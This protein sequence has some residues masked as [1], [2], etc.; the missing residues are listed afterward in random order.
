[1]AARAHRACPACGV[2][3]PTTVG[4]QPARWCGS[5]GARLAP[6]PPADPDRRRPWASPGLPAIVGVALLA[7][8]LALGV[9]AAGERLASPSAGSLEVDL[10]R[11]DVAAVVTGPVSDDGPVCLRAPDC[12]AWIAPASIAGRTPTATVAGELTLVRVRDGV[13]ARDTDDGSLQWR[14]PLADAADRSSYLPVL[15]V[16]HLALLTDVR[17]D[18]GALVALDL[19]SGDVRWRI[20]GVTEVVDVEAQG[21][22]QGE[23][24]LVQ[25]L[26]P[27][28]GDADGTSPRHRSRVEEVLAVEPVTGEV[29]WSARGDLLHLVGDGA[30]VVADGEVA[31]V[32]ATGDDLW[33]RNLDEDLTPA[34][35]DVT[36]RF[37]RLYDG[38][39]RSGPTWSLTDGEAIEVEGELVPVAD[40]AAPPG[41]L[42]DGDLAAL[43]RRQVDGATDLTLLDGDEV[44]WRVTFDQLGCCAP[45]QLEEDRIV[46]PAADGG[47]WHLAR[48]DGEVLE[49]TAPLP[50]RSGASAYLPSY[51]G[52]TV[53]EL[54]VAATT[55]TDLALIDAGVRTA[56]LPAGTWPVGATDEVVVVRSHGWVAAVQRSPDAATADHPDADPAD[57]EPSRP[58][59]PPSSAT[60]RSERQG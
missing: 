40:L 8:L 38:Q 10:D 41:E 32:G 50:N 17:A 28:T 36:G 47:R 24:L 19:A 12:V 3:T 58:G 18:D 30:V 55:T 6:L 42:F 60:E 45:I 35:L 52:Y 23:V 29:R 51:G 16:G 59:D 53:E 46:V 11:E 2:E 25:V 31:V 57:D 1:V 13:E 48:E 39:G 33:R 4:R 26:R 27:R 15:T 43:V 37:L 44:R 5:C 21:E 7:A 56:R 54:D 14:T 9:N 49:R 22:A 20:D 34:W